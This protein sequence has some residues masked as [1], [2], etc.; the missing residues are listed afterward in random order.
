V[1]V[2]IAGGLL[3][4]SLRPSYPILAYLGMAVLGLIALGLAALIISRT[5]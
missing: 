2:M 1:T 3:E 4:S 5:E